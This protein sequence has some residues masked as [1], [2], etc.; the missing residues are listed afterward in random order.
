MTLGTQPSAWGVTLRA[1]QHRCAFNPGVAAVLPTGRWPKKKLKSGI[2]FLKLFKNLLCQS[3]NKVMHLACFFFGRRVWHLLLWL[4]KL[5][6]LII[7]SLTAAGREGFFFFLG[8]GVCGV[9]EETLRGLEGCKNILC[10]KGKVKLPQ[11]ILVPLE[12]TNGYA[13]GGN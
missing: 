2:F 5:A 9:A 10:R 7:S 13:T 3:V 12:P 11:P 4:K 8:S 1:G 6:T